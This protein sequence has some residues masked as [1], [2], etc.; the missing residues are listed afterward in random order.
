MFE[1]F[2]LSVNLHPLIITIVF[3]E[4][5]AIQGLK[6]LLD[7]RLKILRHTNP[8]RAKILIFSILYHPFK[9]ST[10]DW[11]TIKMQ[12]LDNLIRH[13]H[14]ICPTP[15]ELEEKLH[16][17]AQKGNQNEEDFTTASVIFKA[18]KP[19]YKNPD[20][21]NTKEVI[22]SEEQQLSSDVDNTNEILSL[23]N[24]DRL[25]DDSKPDLDDDETQWLDLSNNNLAFNWK[26]Q[27]S[28]SPSNIEAHNDEQAEEDDDLTQPLFIDIDYLDET[29]ENISY[30]SGNFDSS[31]IE[32]DRPEL[33]DID[34]YGGRNTDLQNACSSSKIFPIKTDNNRSNIT[35]SFLRK[36]DLEDEVQ[37]LIDGQAQKVRASL[38]DALRS[39]EEEID[40]ISIDRSQI[41][42]SSIKYPALQQLTDRLSAHLSQIQ[43]ILRVQAKASIS[44]PP[45]PSIT[46]LSSPPTTS[47]AT[48]Q[49]IL[50]LL[51]PMLKPQGIKTFV[52]QKE[53]CLHIVLESYSAATSKESPTPNPQQLIPFVRK[54]LLNIN[55][56]AIDQIKVYGRKPGHQSPEWI[57]T[58]GVREISNK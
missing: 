24:G 16:K 28:F 45:P 9:F 11:L 47:P 51:K 15:T 37:R 6:D 18:M 29:R 44:A 52:K 32:N 22:S 17:T 10:R 38:V 35:T 8:L 19:L 30:D 42:R 20:I 21:D 12:D 39:V 31:K 53:G 36:I 26:P 54:A 13:L 56:E 55:L 41:D 50:A 7:V 27:E 2:F 5:T 34:L 40:R 1:I 58:I 4:S 57:Q 46:P 23:D 3:S 25:T 14:S 43:D 33:P 49:S 48:P